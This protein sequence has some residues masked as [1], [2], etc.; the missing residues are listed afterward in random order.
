MSLHNAINEL[1]KHPKTNQAAI[2]HLIEHQHQ[3]DK[4]MAQIETVLEQSKSGQVQ[5]LYFMDL[6]ARW[7]ELKRF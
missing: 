3:L 7:L 1:M 4:L 5:P 6:E 2:E